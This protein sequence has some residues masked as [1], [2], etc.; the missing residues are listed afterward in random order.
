M[1]NYEEEQVDKKFIELLQEQIGKC[2]NI[3]SIAS[4]LNVDHVY[5]YLSNEGGQ[6][7]T[8]TENYLK[9]AVEN[10]EY[11]AEFKECA[12]YD[13]N[14]GIDCAGSLYKKLGYLRSFV[15]LLKEQ[16]I[17]SKY[18]ILK[19]NVGSRDV[20]VAMWFN[21]QMDGF[22]NF[23]MKPTIENLGYNPV[24][25]DEHQHNNK[26]D[27]EIIALI[28]RSVFL[29]V[30]LTGNR[31]GVYY[32]AGYAKGL[33]IQVVYSVRRDE[34]DLVHFDIEH[35]NLIIWNNIEEYSEEL[36]KRIRGTFGEFKE[37][38]RE[39]VFF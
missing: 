12:I 5:V 15:K 32:E 30:D 14:G 21:E 4:G 16:Y 17:S 1:R 34:F 10:Q 28:E 38:Q 24:R 37:P 31:G 23:G 9:Y 13:F 11:L 39:E 33:G 35:E 36:E 3:L 6:W 29:V 22:Y 27:L 26:I 7:S 8:E 25:V 20:F 18:S 19:N 2:E